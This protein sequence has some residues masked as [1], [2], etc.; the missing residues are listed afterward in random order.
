MPASRSSKEAAEVAATKD[1]AIKV[2]MFFRAHACVGVWGCGRGYVVVG[3][4]VP[5]LHMQDQRI[6]H[7]QQQQLECSR[8]GIK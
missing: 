8:N 2:L 1:P 3:V 4:D 5:C 6:V 7:T